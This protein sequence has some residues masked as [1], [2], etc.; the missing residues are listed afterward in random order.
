MRIPWPISKVKIMVGFSGPRF[1]DTRRNRKVF[2]LSRRTSRHWNDGLCCQGCQALCFVAFFFFFLGGGGRYEEP[3]ACVFPY[4]WR[5]NFSQE[6]IIQ[7]Q[8]TFNVSY[9]GSS[10]YNMRGLH[11]KA[12]E[13][14]V[15][16]AK[17][18]E[19]T[20]GPH[21]RSGFVFAARSWT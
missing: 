5:L 7:S 11:Y 3:C 12:K 19:D 20:T 13:E 16:P 14:I 4:N 9:V 17:A 2:S 8:S 1:Q 6:P 21:F 18:K 10:H 15:S